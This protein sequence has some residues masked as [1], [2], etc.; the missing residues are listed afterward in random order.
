MHE[1][2]RLTSEFP[3][4]VDGH[5]RDRLGSALKNALGEGIDAFAS[6]ALKTS[7]K[8]LDIGERAVFPAVLI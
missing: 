8:F 2:R 1:Q 6:V 4:T 3:P 7:V 5:F